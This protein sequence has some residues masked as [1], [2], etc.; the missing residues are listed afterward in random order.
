MLILTVKLQIVREVP[1]DGVVH[2]HVDVFRI[3][4][5]AV[6]LYNARVA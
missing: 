2:H 1:V 5:R 6:K 4:E 3:C